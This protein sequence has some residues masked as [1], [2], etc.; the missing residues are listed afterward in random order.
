MNVE[1][2]LLVSLF[3]AWRYNCITRLRIRKGKTSLPALAESRVAWGLRPPRIF[4]RAGSAVLRFRGGGVICKKINLGRVGIH[5]EMFHAI[6]SI[7]DTVQARVKTPGGYTDILDNEMGVL[8]GCILSPLLFGLFLDPLEKLLLASD[9]K[10]PKVLDHPLPAQF[11]AD[12]SQLLS[13]TPKGLQTAID[14]LQNFCEDN[15]LTV[16]LS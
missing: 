9:S 10:P 16:N 3:L 13:T 12:D 11:F 8:Q 2:H 1:K 7:Y 4:T 6:Q 15:G 14:T 5:G